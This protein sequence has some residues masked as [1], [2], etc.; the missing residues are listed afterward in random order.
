MRTANKLSLITYALLVLVVCI[1]TLLGM[2]S[3]VLASV[4]VIADTV[5]TLSSSL[6]CLLA[7]FY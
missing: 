4:L 1:F 7:L 6:L 2:T 3:D 5:Q